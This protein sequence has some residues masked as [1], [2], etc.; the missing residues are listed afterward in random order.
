MG[1]DGGE[2]VNKRDSVSS[3][4]GNHLE[5]KLLE[6]ISVRIWGVSLDDLTYNLALSLALARNFAVPAL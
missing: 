2:R 1:S 5:W 3:D 6:I 4:F